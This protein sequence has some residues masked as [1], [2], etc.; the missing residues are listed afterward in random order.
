MVNLVL[1]KWVK[2]GEI[3]TDSSSF[4]VSCLVLVVVNCIH[5][6]YLVFWSV[7]GGGI[8]ENKVGNLNYQG[9]E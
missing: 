3:V 9:I 6:V 5:P 2:R 8:R 1:E 4:L 7:Q